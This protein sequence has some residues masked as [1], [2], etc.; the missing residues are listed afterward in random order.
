M[1]VYTNRLADPPLIGY[2]PL[3]PME[4][5]DEVDHGACSDGLHSWVRSEIISGEVRKPSSGNAPVYWKVAESVIWCMD[6]G[7]AIKERTTERSRIK[8]AR[9]YYRMVNPER[10]S[11]RGIDPEFMGNWSIAGDDEIHRDWEQEA[12][13]RGGWLR[14]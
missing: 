13:M 4:Y 5:R 14:V 1:Y 3:V 8:S 12:F 11:Y 10:T 6:C 7:R 2:I 9:D